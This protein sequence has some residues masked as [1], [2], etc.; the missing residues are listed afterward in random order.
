MS[1]LIEQ[2]T[3]N[4]IFCLAKKRTKNRL[5]TFDRGSTVENVNLAFEQNNQCSNFSDEG[6]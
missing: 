3:T 1:F 6:K 2:H 4:V 5:S